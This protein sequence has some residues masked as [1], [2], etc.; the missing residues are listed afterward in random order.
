MKDI[1]EGFK[2]FISRGNVVELAVAVVIGGA[3]GKIVTNIVDAIITPLIAAVFGSTSLASALS[4]Q[5]NDAVFRPGLVLDA[6]INF[7]AVAAAVYFLI[8]LPMNKLAERR[9]RGLE[10]EPE[11]KAEDVQLLEEIR[12]LLRAQAAGP[13]PGTPQPGTPQA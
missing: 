6:I 10:P 8:V 13:Q 3:F 1:V 9:A 5:I 12:D 4:F 11:V 2:N 7:L